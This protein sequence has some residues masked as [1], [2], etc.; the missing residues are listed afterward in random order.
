MLM[1]TTI[2][3][4]IAWQGNG[5]TFRSEDKR[6]S[7]TGENP[8][9]LT[10]LPA[11]QSDGLRFPYPPDWP[12]ATRKPRLMVP[13]LRRGTC[14]GTTPACPTAV[15]VQLPPRTTRSGTPAAPV[16]S[17][18]GDFASY[19]SYPSQHHS[20]TFPCMS[21]SPQ[22]FGSLLPPEAVRLARNTAYF[23]RISSSPPLAN[24]VVVPARQAYSHSASVGRR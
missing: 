3:R 15:A 13:V 21:N 20:Q 4:G 16:G 2:S 6:R 12:R 18:A 17:T 8:A 7:I 10:P 14:S 11:R 23:R 1:S 22:P 5:T 9:K 24:S 19:F